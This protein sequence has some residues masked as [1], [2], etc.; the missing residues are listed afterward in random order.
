MQ[1]KYIHRETG[2]IDDRE[3][4]LEA[5]SAEE[6]EDRG[7]KTAEEAFDYDV[8]N[9]MLIEQEYCEN[10]QELTGQESG[11][12]LFDNGDAIACNWSSV[13]GIPRMAPFGD[14]VTGLGE[15]IPRIEGVEIDDMGEDLEGVRFIYA[16]GE[17]MPTAG[18]RY[19]LKN[20]GLTVY[21][22][23]GWA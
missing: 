21:A 9:G 10:L 17:E 1:T 3:G 5:Y 18:K 8:E 22:P 6:L 20:L 4:W 23:Y 15:L 11:I 14:F 16:N 13:Q 7:F 19:Q 12:I 2:S